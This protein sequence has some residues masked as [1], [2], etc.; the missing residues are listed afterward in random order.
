MASMPKSEIIK[1]YAEFNDMD[2][3]TLGEQ[4]DEAVM[5]LA[6]HWTRE[7]TR[8]EHICYS[9]QRIVEILMRDGMTEL[10][11]WEY[12]EFN[13]FGAYV[14][15]GTPV[16]TDELIDVFDGNYIADFEYLQGDVADL[17]NIEEG[18]L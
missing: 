6:E 7:G 10:E 1:E 5:G 14:G 18:Q 2:L 4:F 3:L 9:K 15:K 11:A 12:A 13:I 16:Y 17:F 8:R